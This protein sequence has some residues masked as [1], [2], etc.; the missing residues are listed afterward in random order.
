MINY[1]DNLGSIK[2]IAAWHRRWVRAI[3]DATRNTP[4]PRPA[5]LGTS[6]KSVIG[7]GVF[8]ARPTPDFEK[9]VTLHFVV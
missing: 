4:Q 3:A 6:P 5:P 1:E 9:S 2:V 7:P 8:T